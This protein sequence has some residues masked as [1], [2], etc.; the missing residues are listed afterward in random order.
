M[1]A[2]GS[3]AQCDHDVGIIAD[4]E[5]QYPADAL[6][7]I[8]TFSRTAKAQLP[9]RERLREPAR[10]RSPQHRPVIPTTTPPLLLRR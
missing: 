2:A 8:L 7:S 1:I 6:I 9:N 10:P 4:R 5:A 3:F